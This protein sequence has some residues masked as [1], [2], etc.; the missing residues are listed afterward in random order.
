MKSAVMLVPRYDKVIAVDEEHFWRSRALH[1]WRVFYITNEL[2]IQQRGLNHDAFG[3]VA[4]VSIA[5]AA[6][7]LRLG[8]SRSSLL[9]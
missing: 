4:H 5:W 7:G 2:S 8:A 6:C 9:R 3:R 1:L